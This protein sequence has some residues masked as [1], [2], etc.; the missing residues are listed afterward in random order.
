MRIRD[1]NI[2]IKIFAKIEKKIIFLS[3][4][5]FDQEAKLFD[6]E[7]KFCDRN[8]L[9][10]RLS[11]CNRSNPQLKSDIMQL[12]FSSDELL[13]NLTLISSYSKLKKIITNVAV[14]KKKKTIK[15]RFI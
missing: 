3:V 14:G 11:S 15:S 6:D 5:D 4:C 1:E 9:I 8:R 10:L 13:T 7:E 12:S 2:F